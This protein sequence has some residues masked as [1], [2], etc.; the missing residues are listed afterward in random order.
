MILVLREWVAWHARFGRIRQW[1][2]H[3]AASMRHKCRCECGSLLQQAPVG[4]VK[5]AK[6]QDCTTGS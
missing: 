1:L 4:T 6:A 3:A 2:Q 5:P